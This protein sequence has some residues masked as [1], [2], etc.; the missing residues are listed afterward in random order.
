[1]HFL[2]IHLLAC[3]LRVYDHQDRPVRERI[4]DGSCSIC[5][6]A[7]RS[8]GQGARPP[9]NRG[10]HAPELQGQQQAIGS[11]SPAWMSQIIAECDKYF[12]NARLNEKLR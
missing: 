5:C 8:F 12:A 6:R 3:L 10:N 2:I 4:R 11:C 1:M 9:C 7:T